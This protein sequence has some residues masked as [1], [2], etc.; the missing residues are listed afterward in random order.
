MSF[1]LTNSLYFLVSTPFL[2]S[3]HIK[4]RNQEVTNQFL[5]RFI[6]PLSSTCTP[7]FW[8]SELPGH[9]A[10]I[11]QLAVQ[12]TSSRLRVTIPSPHIC[13]ICLSLQGIVC[14]T[15]TSELLIS[16]WKLSPY[17]VSLQP[18]RCFEFARADVGFA[19]ESR[20][21]LRAQI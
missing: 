10:K 7:S 8:L 2:P 9:A 6:S 12:S 13:N 17:T 20:S 19:D 5:V 11:E 4:Y 14:Q 21:R 3:T 18:C 1:D 15:W 16:I